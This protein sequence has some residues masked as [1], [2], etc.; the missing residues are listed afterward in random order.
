MTRKLT[1]AMAGLAFVLALLAATDA[2][3]QQT[4]VYGPDGRVRERITTDSQGSRTVYDASGRVTGRTSTDSQG[5]TTIYDASGRRT[6]TVTT[7]GK[8]DAYAMDAVFRR[9]HRAGDNYADGGRTMTIHGRPRC[10]RHVR[11]WG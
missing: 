7:A 11:Y 8:N 1:G 6:G 9:R 4:T 5:T 2:L 10:R 3:A